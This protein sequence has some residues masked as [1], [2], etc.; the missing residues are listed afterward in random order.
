MRAAAAVVVVAVAHS[1]ARTAGR[2]ERYRRSVVVGFGVLW[3]LS[4]G[5]GLYRGST[6]IAFHH[7]PLYDRFGGGGGGGGGG[8]CAVFDLVVAG[9]CGGEEMAENKTNK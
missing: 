4:L 6:V 3:L 9:G 8:G 2:S 5:L 1:G 7:R